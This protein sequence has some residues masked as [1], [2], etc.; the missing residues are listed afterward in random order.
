MDNGSVYELGCA[1]RKAYLKPATLKFDQK[2]KRVYK[3]GTQVV[4]LTADGKMFTI[5]G[6]KSTPIASVF[7]GKVLEMVPQQ[8]FGLTSV[9][10]LLLQ[11]PQAFQSP[12][13]NHCLLPV[14][15]C[16]RKLLTFPVLQHPYSTQSS[17]AN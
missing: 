2:Y 4:G 8:S 5:D 17:A 16:P 14:N 3:V 13:V 12:K 15:P 7:N 6:M 11:Q 1:S 9:Q 10:Q